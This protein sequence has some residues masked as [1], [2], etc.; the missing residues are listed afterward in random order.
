MF[1][2]PIRVTTI[3]QMNA[4][5]QRI[6][7]NLTGIGTSSPH[8]HGTLQLCSAQYT[9]RRC[10]ARLSIAVPGRV[11]LSV[12]STQSL[13]IILPS[14]YRP[15][16]LEHTRN[17]RHTRFLGRIALL[18]SMIASAYRPAIRPPWLLSTRGI[19][20][21]RPIIGSLKYQLAQRVYLPLA[22][23]TACLA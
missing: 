6:T 19:W 16:Q 2:T 7:G 17:R 22:I 20:S 14:T 8:R 18:D 5:C 10:Q 13:L 15:K 9:T 23:S 4:S 21:T 11:A 1:G 12:M 3:K